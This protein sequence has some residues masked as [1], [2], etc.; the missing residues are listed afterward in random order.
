MT[1]LYRR[2]S[3]VEGSRSSFAAAFQDEDIES[4]RRGHREELGALRGRIAKTVQ[5]AS[6]RLAT[7]RPDG[8]E[9][10]SDRQAEVVERMA[11][12]ADLAG[13]DRGAQFRQRRDRVVRSRQC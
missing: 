6:R 4:F 8:L 9:G 10:L 13:E 3:R 11:A 2:R 12:I 7:A 5:S 1:V